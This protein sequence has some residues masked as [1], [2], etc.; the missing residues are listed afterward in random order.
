ME[1]PERVEPSAF[2]KRVDNTGLLKPFEAAKYIVPV[3]VAVVE[4]V[5][6]S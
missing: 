6:A 2:I 3:V 1:P 5:G 4:G